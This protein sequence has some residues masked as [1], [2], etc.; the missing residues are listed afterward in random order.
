VLSIPNQ[1]NIEIIVVDDLS[2]QE[3]LEPVNKL[4]DVRDNI[5]VVYAKDNKGAGYARNKGIEIARG[6][7][8]LFADADDFFE[9][10]FV[11]I[12]DSYK[13][14]RYD[15][16]YYN[17]VSCYSDTYI[18]ANRH[19]DIDEKIKRYVNGDIF[20]ENTLRFFFYYPYC[21]MIKR[22]LVLANNVKYDEI[23]ITNDVMF[24]LMVGYFAKEIMAVDYPIYCITVRSDSISRN[25]SEE[26]F[27]YR[28]DTALRVDKFMRSIGVKNCRYSIFEY[29]VQSRRYGLRK[30]FEI[31]KRGIKNES[32]IFTGM[33][34]YILLKI[35]E[36]L[37]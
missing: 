32:N 27:D 1:D 36:Y 7:W 26:Y 16:V 6:K 28:V 13:D 29:I 19:N 9:K 11:R 35:K 20:S 5:I 37:F 22:D 10:D 3:Y 24:S 34:K 8:L 33:E 25:R 21:K 12:L 18:S 17:A 30:I 14:E 4:Y 2:N 23:P 15:I 31:A